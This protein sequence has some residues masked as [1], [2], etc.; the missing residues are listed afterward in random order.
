MEEIITLNKDTKYKNI[1]TK[2]K[3][4]LEL[5]INS[6]KECTLFDNLYNDC[7]KF[8]AKKVTIDNKA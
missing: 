6:E 4:L 1:C 7:I 5:C 8:K 3:K 2:E